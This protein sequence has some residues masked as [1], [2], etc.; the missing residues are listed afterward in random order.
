[1]TLFNQKCQ[2]WL[3]WNPHMNVTYD[4]VSRRQLRIFNKEA[5]LKGQD[6]TKDKDEDLDK[7]LEF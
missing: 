2:L 1:M 6:L 7:H 5:K 4:E 3:D